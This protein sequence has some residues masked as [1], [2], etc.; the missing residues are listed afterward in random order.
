MMHDSVPQ[1]VCHASN[2]IYWFI[3][4]EKHY[5]NNNLILSCY[6][7]TVE[8]YGNAKKFADRVKQFYLVILSATKQYRFISYLLLGYLISYKTISFH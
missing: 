5:I 2:V 3:L 8:N 4:S 1:K 7:A 6:G